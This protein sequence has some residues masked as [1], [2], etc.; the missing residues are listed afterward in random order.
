[1]NKNPIEYIDRDLA[2]LALFEAETECA[3]MDEKTVEKI[4][5]LAKNKLD[6]VKKADVA[7]V[8]HARWDSSISVVPLCTACGNT[9]GCNM[10]NPLY[11]P[12]F[13]A[14][15]GGDSNA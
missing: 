7:P 4:F 14:R 8:V 13:G 12:H 2:E 1:M 15:M 3:G 6:S 10:R 9:H 5:A 11:C